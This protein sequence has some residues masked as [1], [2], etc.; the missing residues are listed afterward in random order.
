MF[1]VPL[2][3]APED[4]EQLRRKVCGGHLVFHRPRYLLTRVNV[5]RIDLD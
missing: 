3:F 4:G 1:S 2:L 5:P